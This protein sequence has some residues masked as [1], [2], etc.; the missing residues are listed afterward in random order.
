MQGDKQRTNHSLSNTFT[1]VLCITLLWMLLALA[2]LNNLCIFT[3]DIDSA[4]LHGKIDHDIYIV[5]LDGY[6]RPGKVVRLNKVL[7]GLPEAT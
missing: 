1:P 2:T 4:Y 5:F 6:S 7:Y 3:W